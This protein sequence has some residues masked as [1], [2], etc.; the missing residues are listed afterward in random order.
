MITAEIIA[1][2]TEILLGQIDNTHARHLSLDL[3]AM[4][5]A[6]YFHTSVGDNRERLMNTVTLAL[7]RSQVII[8]T[9]GLG[10]T[11]DDLTRAAVAA[12]CGLPLVFSQ[13]AFDAHVA[14]Y[15]TRLGRVP[16]EP[17]RQQAMRIGS[18]VFFPNARGT[19]PGQHVAWMGRH[20]FLLPGPPLEMQP[21]YRESVRPVLI[22]L[23]GGGVIVSRMIRLYGIGESEA[24]QRVEDI[25][26]GQSNPTIAP[27]AS[28]GEMALRITA[29]AASERAARE[30]IAPA[31][32]MLL[33]RLGQY[34]Y[35]FDDDSLAQTV[36]EALR[37][38]RARVACAESCTGGLLTSLLVDIPGS[39]DCVHGSV[40]AYDDDVK[41]RLLC[42]PPEIL[43]THGAVSGEAAGEMAAGVRRLMAA[44]Y[45]VSVTGIAGPSGGTPDKPVGLVYLAVASER[46]VVVKKRVFSGDRTQIRIRSAKA[47]LH[48]LLQQLKY[49]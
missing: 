14:P 18:A 30:M 33:E 34:V 31:E 4:G 41:E 39:S 10:P 17:N 32:S 8:I 5:V 25:L 48:L 16:A 28:E 44:D 29:R 22:S 19:A 12:A 24:H 45:G 3:A 6:V 37:A 11:D 38:R 2:G 15:F 36:L 46:G 42:V 49:S 35:G 9:G 13:E 43:A 20:I 1:V 26:R 27:L 47:A 23:A 40:V 7:E 21:M